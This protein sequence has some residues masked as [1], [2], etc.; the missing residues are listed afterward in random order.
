MID[1]RNADCVDVMRALPDACVDA[2]ITDPPYA[3]IGKKHKWDDFESRAIFHDWTRGWLKEAFRLQRNRYACVFWSQLYVSEFELVLTGTGWQTKHVLCW[4]QRNP[5]KMFRGG[6]QYSWQ[7]CFI[8]AKPGGPV[9]LGKKEDVLDVW[10]EDFPMFRRA[11]HPTCK[12]L[13]LMERL[14]R[15][16]TARGD[17]VL[18][19][20]M[21]SGTTGVACLLHDRGFIG[22]ERDARYFKYASWRINENKG[23]RHVLDADKPLETFPA[24]I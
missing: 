20:F 12:P 1:L 10:R 14:V 16:Y 15:K 3:V 23:Q 5:P 21:G 24:P 19:P 18:D 7:P 6:L 2:V 9:K 13:R 4:H 17:V 11:K 8:I 22:V